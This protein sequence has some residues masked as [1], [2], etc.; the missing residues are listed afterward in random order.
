[1]SCWRQHPEHW[2]AVFHKEVVGTDTEL[3]PSFG[4]P[5][6]SGISAK[7]N[8]NQAG[9]LQTGKVV[10]SRSVIRGYFL[11][12]GSEASPPYVDGLID[13]PEI[14]VVGLEARFLID[15]G[16]DRSLLGDDDAGRM[17]RDYEVDL[18]RL[19]DGIPS[20]GIGGVV[21]TREV[22]A[23][24]GLGDFS[25]SIRLDVLEPKFWTTSQRSFSTRS[26][27]T[28]AL[29]AV[30]GRAYGQGS[31]PGSARGRQTGARIAPSKQVR[32]LP[33]RLCPELALVSPSERSVRLG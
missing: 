19:E 12:T 7:Q 20:Q 16:A 23:T 32:R 31:P 14:G 6:I 25:T 21:A 8:D 18:G 2:V 22:Q 26:G 1:M 4:R 33:L 11:P 27:H 3:L 28:L 15:T 9:H 24:L 17:L 13:I 30:R 10:P 5:E 29:R